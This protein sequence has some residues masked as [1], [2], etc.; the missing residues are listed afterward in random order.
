[1]RPPRLTDTTDSP[2]SHKRCPDYHQSR[3]EDVTGRASRSCKK[4]PTWRRG[5]HR[6]QYLP[7]MGA[8]CVRPRR[9]GCFASAPNATHT[10]PIN[11]PGG[12]ELRPARTC[13][14]PSSA[15]EGW[16]TATREDVCLLPPKDIPHL[17]L[18][19][20]R[21]NSTLL[22]GHRGACSADA[23]YLG[24]SVSERPGGWASRLCSTGCAA[25][26]FPIR[27]WRLSRCLITGDTAADHPGDHVADLS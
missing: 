18:L 7:G 6:L 25:G 9:A 12:P 14:L 11:P 10:E 21:G 26:R 22:G 13:E 27:L 8:G 5:L 23:G 16:M 15:R 17:H 3:S 20:G 1:M 2:S 24:T 19:S 4:G